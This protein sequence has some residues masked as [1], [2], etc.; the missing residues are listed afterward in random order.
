[1]PSARVSCIVRKPSVPRLRVAVRPA[2]P[3]AHAHAAH[4]RVHI[5]IRMYRC[6]MPVCH[7]QPQH[8]VRACACARHTHAPRP[9]CAAPRKGS[10]RRL[11]RR[12]AEVEQRDARPDGSRSAGH[13]RYA[14]PDRPVV[15]PP[16]SVRTCVGLLARLRTHFV[17]V[18]GS[19]PLRPAQK[20]PAQPKKT[21][22]VV[23]RP[24]PVCPVCPLVLLPP[25]V[26]GRQCARAAVPLCTVSRRAPIRGT[27][28]AC[29]ALAGVRR[30]QNSLR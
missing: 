26:T 30:A 25:W 17:G 20:A 15:Q 27:P 3:M 14:A 16:P 19:G 10:A 29:A 7:A 6:H 5:C 18:T 23:R 22:A 1:M 28:I 12:T 2:E 8:T 4:V 9:R 24:D 13:A 21:D 11:L